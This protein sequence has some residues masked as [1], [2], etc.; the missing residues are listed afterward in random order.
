MLENA[1]TI[2]G[3]SGPEKDIL[4]ST[5]VEPLELQI[6]E[7]IREKRIRDEMIE[8]IWDPEWTPDTTLLAKFPENTDTTPK[9]IERAITK[10]LQYETIKRREQ[11]IAPTFGS[12]YDWVFQR[13]PRE[14]NGIPSWSSVPNWLE[15][16]ASGI[17][18][19]TGKPG[20]GKS[21]MMKFMMQ[22]ARLRKYLH[23]WS[24]GIPFFIGHYYAWSIG[25]QLDKSRTGLMRSLLH[26]IISVQPNLAPMLCPRR[27]TLFHTTRDSLKFPEWSEWEL[28]ESLMALVRH[29]ESNMRILLFIDGLDEFEAPPMEIITLIGRI[30]AEPSIKIC[31]ASRPWPEFRDA[32]LGRPS[33]QMHHLN[34]EDIK[35]YTNLH[36]SKSPGFLEVKGIYPEA[37]NSLVN[38]VVAKSKGVFLWTTIVTKNLL[39]SL[40]EGANLQKLRIILDQLPE[41][42]EKLYDAIFATIPPRLLPE[43]SVMLLIFKAACHPLDWFSMWLADEFRGANLHPDPAVDVSKLWTTALPSL[44]RRLAARTRGLLEVS[45]PTDSQYIGYLHRTVA[46]WI[47]RPGVWEQI[48]SNL[49]SDFDPYACLFLAEMLLMYPLHPTSH[50]QE[51]WESIARSLFY[52]SLTRCPSV[53]TSESQLVTAMDTINLRAQQVF[54]T[55]PGNNQTTNHIWTQD[56][57]RPTNFLGLAAEFCVAPYVRANVTENSSQFKELCNVECG[58]LKQAIF[59]PQAMFRKNAMGSLDLNVIPKENR[60]QLVKFLIQHKVESNDDLREKILRK[61]TR[62]EEYFQEIVVLMGSKPGNGKREF[63]GKLFKWRSSRGR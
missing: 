41:D 4:L 50:R 63:A 54:N 61:A 51:F 38:D 2:I 39:V 53:N 23:I 19:I 9:Q 55:F 42:I 60:I 11:A 15:S 45:G 59:G 47:E 48:S 33:M 52:A 37:A 27:W 35:M 3:Q 13:Q 14:L 20:S 6:R 12:T 21:T 34:H 36:F 5:G 46:E 25:R 1:V 16:D 56:T 22:D 26:Q 57:G 18:W 62:G 24:A 28:E 30:A 32:F 44:K 10:T 49:P 8:L 17:Y 43:T 29:A 31:A 40:S 58:L 7:T